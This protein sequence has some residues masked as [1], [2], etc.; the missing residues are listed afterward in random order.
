MQR[1]IKGETKGR[2]HRAARRTARLCRVLHGV[3]PR[4]LHHGLSAEPAAGRGAAPLL[5]ARGAMVCRAVHPH[6]RHFVGSLA[7]QPRARRQALRGGAARDARHGRRCAAGTHCVRH[8]ALSQH[9]HDGLRPAAAAAPPRGPRAPAL[10]PVARGAV[11]RARGRA[12]E[13]AAGLCAD[14][15]SCCAR[16]CRARG[17]RCGL[18]RLACR[19]RA[20]PPPIISPSSRGVSCSPPVR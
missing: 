19:G 2:A 20:F 10:P 9:L 8:P 16:S 18:R 7:L 4:L 14:P 13:R 15:P 12:L 3:L 6:R 17:T 1:E 11:R 5:H